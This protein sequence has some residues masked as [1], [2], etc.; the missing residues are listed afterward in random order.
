[1]Y[2]FDLKSL[3]FQNLVGAG[4]DMKSAKTFNG[5]IHFND[6]SIYAMGGN[7]KDACERFD[8]YQ[9]KWEVL[10]SYGEL[11]QGTSEL[12]GWCQIYCS[13]RPPSGIGNGSAMMQQSM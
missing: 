8:M 10:M 11:C 1:M 13:G 2:L 4:G 7:D 9:N 5:V 3:K 12:N 6:G